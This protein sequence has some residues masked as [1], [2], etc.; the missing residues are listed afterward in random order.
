MYILYFKVAKFRF[1]KLCSYDNILHTDTSLVVH[2]VLSQLLM[3]WP[4]SV[5]VF[6]MTSG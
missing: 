1:I 6:Q 2:F 4:Y 3:W 5:G